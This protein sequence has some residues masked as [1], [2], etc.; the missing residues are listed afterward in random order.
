MFVFGFAHDAVVADQG[1]WLVDVAVDSE[2]VAWLA[3][4]VLA[5][6]HANHTFQTIKFVLFVYAAPAQF[7]GVSFFVA[8]IDLGFC[9]SLD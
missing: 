1:G 9:A 6:G 7:A 3:C 4:C 2:W 5:N 8:P